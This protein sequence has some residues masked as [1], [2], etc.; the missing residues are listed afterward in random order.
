MH[1]GYSRGAAWSAAHARINGERQQA[2]GG[3][4]DGVSEIA[5]LWN[6]WNGRETVANSL[7]AS[8]AAM[9]MAR[10]NTARERCGAGKRGNIVDAAASLAIYEAIKPLGGG[11]ETR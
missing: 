8:D 3:P 9:M 1:D 2:Y 10:R 4:Y 6:G 7:S 11:H 5:R